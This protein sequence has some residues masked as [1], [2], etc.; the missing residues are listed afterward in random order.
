[1][2]NRTLSIGIVGL[3]NVGKSTLFNALLKR[4]AALVANYPFATI[5]PNVGIVPVPD[6][7]LHILAD[8][9]R[10]DN[11]DKSGDKNMPEKITPTA[12]KFYDIA[13]LVKN[14]HKGE[15]LGNEFLSHIREVDAILHVVRVFDD[16]N[17]ARAGSVSPEE[18]KLTINTELV[19]ADLATLEKRMQPF[20]KELKKNP[21]KE[22]REKEKVY[23]K[24]YDAFNETILASNLELTNEEKEYLKDLNLLTLKP[25]VYVYNVSE[26]TLNSDIAHKLTKEGTNSVIV[27][28]KFENELST[29]T[30][31]DKQEILELYS[32]PKDAISAIIIKG[33]DVLGLSTYFTMGPKEVKA[34]TITKGTKAPQAAGIIHT[35][36]E[37]GFISAEIINYEDLKEL[38]SYKGAKEKGLIRKEGKEYVM[39]EGDVVQFRFS[40]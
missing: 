14:A 6:E 40:V 1:M 25:M 10:K 5:E 8:I 26:D 15:G 16:E 3:P 36:F 11:G 13:G 31:D 23:K 39:R 37:R 29:L 32:V 12:I 22:N 7:R 9:V 4:Q 19:L 30:E 33:Y 34:W 17:I 38:G 2:A 24:L 27:S 20:D 28:A 35:D 18:D 21:S